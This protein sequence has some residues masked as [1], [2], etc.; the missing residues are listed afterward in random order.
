[1]ESNKGSQTALIVSSALIVSLMRAVHSC[2]DRNPII[3]DPYG[4]DLVSDHE[5]KA[6]RNRLS[7]ALSAENIRHLQRI[8]DE[9]EALAEVFRLYEGYGNVI[10]RTC[11]AES[12]LDRAIKDGLAQY[13]ILGAGM[14]TFALRRP[15]LV[16]SVRI[17][18]IDHPATQ[19]MKMDRFATAGLNSPSNV[20][21]VEADFE[22]QT[23]G[24]VLRN[25]KF[26]RNMPSY[27]AWLG[28][29]PYLSADAIYNTIESISEIASANS[30]LVFNYLDARFK[31]RSSVLISGNPQRS[32]S[33]KTRATRFEPK[34]IQTMLANCG[35]NV[36]ED[37]G[38]A[39]ITDRFCTGRVDGLRPLPN[40]RIVRAQ[41]F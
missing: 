10:I 37:I 38:A 20:E 2:R 39:E 22:T 7:S 12:Y 17:F 23:T 4:F 33:T 9:D 15:S 36:L 40:F 1:M 29:T 28:V 14:D 3:D 18:E 35:F 6:I 34:E 16:S 31:R 24:D 25:S 27:F 8:D 32:L 11:Y 26:D 13:V 19:K 21:Y 5:L 30:Q 41:L